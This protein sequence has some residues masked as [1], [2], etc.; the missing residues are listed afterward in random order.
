MITRNMNLCVV[1]TEK[2]TILKHPWSKIINM[3]DVDELINYD[4]QQQIL[5]MKKEI[6]FEY[7]RIYNLFKQDMYEEMED[8][9]ENYNFSRIDRGLDFLI[10]NHLKPFVEL[11]FKPIS[12]NYTINLSARDMYNE[13]IFK[14]S[15][16]YQRIIEKF[17]AHIANRYGM[18]EIEN[19][20]LNSGKMIAG[21]CWRRMAHIFIF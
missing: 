12:V 10:E 14:N 2:V 7:V 21:I 9:T 3:C 5:L 19:G 8:G 4:I 16:S 15:E 17:A 6:G 18:E 20:I 13:I 1:D 11:A